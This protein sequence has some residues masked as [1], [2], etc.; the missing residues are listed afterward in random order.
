VFSDDRV[1]HG[2]KRAARLARDASSAERFSA[3][4]L[5]IPLDF[6]GKTLELRGMLRT[7]AVDGVAGLWLR[8]DGDSGVVQFAGM[9]DRGPSGTTKWT[10]YSVTVPIDDHADNV[11]FGVMLAGKGSAWADDLQLLVDGKPV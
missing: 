9:D 10:E 7:E 5:R 1:V 2:G 4:T 3:L 11:A 6:A 8:E